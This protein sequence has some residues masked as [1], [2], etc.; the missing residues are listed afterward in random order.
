MELKL[1]WSI[2][3]EKSSMLYCI[4]WNWIAPSRHMPI[5]SMSTKMVCFTWRLGQLLMMLVT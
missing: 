4:H 2:A 3:P 1:G 5:K